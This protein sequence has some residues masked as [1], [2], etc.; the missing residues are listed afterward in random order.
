MPGAYAPG[1][2]AGFQ[3]VDFSNVIFRTSECW[4]PLRRG[5]KGPNHSKIDEN[6]PEKPLDMLNFVKFYL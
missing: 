1:R 4:N 3:K 2:A 6:R 5:R